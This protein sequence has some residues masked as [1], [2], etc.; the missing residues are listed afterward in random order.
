MIKKRDKLNGK[1][2]ALLIIQ[3]IVIFVQFVQ[4][5]EIVQV[6][7]N[8]Q[9]K[10]ITHDYHLKKKKSIQVI[11]LCIQVMKSYNS[12]RF[13]HLVRIIMSCDKSMLVSCSSEG[14]KLN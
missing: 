7:K 8:I 11:N 14:C 2:S 3:P 10:T 12:L 6:D 13:R 1:L 5:S 4:D 9:P